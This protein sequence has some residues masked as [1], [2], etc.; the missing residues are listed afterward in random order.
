MGFVCK[1]L[2]LLVIVV[3]LTQNSIRI[4]VS[5]FTFDFA[6]IIRETKDQ[7]AFLEEW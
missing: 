4:A 2:L 1:M 5:Y 3:L 7:W 6:L